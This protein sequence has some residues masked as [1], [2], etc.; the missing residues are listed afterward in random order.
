MRSSFSRPHLRVRE[1]TDHIDNKNKLRYHDLPTTHHAGLG[2]T[3]LCELP[4]TLRRG[5]IANGGIALATPVM[6]T[7]TT[8]TPARCAMVNGPRLNS[9]NRPSRLRVPSEH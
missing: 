1:A 8:R 6:V 9:P 5:A 3:P 2:E 7:G 4:L